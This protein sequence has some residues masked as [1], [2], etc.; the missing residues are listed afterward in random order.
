MSSKLTVLAK[1]E[2]IEF[3]KQYARENNTSLSSLINHL[4][5]DLKKHH[6]KK[7]GKYHKSVEKFAGIVSSGHKN[8]LD[9]LFDFRKR[10]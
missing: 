10:K 4:F 2:N 9:E 3:A 8:A 1:K 6:Q 7:N 5:E